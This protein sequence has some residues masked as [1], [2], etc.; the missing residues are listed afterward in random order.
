MF[1]DERHQQILNTLLQQGRITIQEIQDTYAISADS[2]R[3][4]L[5]ILEAKG[6]LKRTHGG[7]I[8]VPPRGFTLPKDYTHRDI[9]TVHPNYMAIALQA[10]SMIAPHEVVHITGGSVGYFMVQHLPKD[11][12]FTV[13][14]NTIDLADI[15]RHYDN[16]TLIFIG[17][18][19]NAKGHC[20]EQLAIDMLQ[21]IRLDK[22][23]ITSG[24]LSVEF[25]AS[26]QSSAACG[27]IR[28]FMASSRI[29]IGL[30]PNEKIQRESIFHICPLSAFN[31][32]ITDWDVTE[33]DMAKLMESDTQIIVAANPDQGSKE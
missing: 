12:P 32:I 16:V 8:Y 24:A 19:M 14:V 13:V 17:G 27:L 30:Y 11:F 25:G 20:R 28:Q 21:Q 6:L 7:A 29:C 9:Q 4:D 2:A 31:A 1:I 23:F 15:L 5:R 26:I 10:V 18:V 33:E 3:R 22:A